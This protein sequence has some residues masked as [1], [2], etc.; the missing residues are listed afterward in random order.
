MRK[1]EFNTNRDVSS[2]ELRPRRTFYNLSPPCLGR[3]D[4]FELTNGLSINASERNAIF[5]TIYHFL[6]SRVEKLDRSGGNFTWTA[7]EGYVCRMK[8][9]KNVC[10]EPE[11][12]REYRRWTCNSSLTSQV[13]YI[14]RFVATS[15]RQCTFF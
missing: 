4:Y 15:C 7:N 1:I 11:T 9:K 5:P 13:L 10:S 12:Q 8:P 2:Q 6:M 3:F 14:L